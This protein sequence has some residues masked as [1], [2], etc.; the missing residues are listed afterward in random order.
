MKLV[1]VA[2]VAQCYGL[3]ASPFVQGIERGRLRAEVRNGVY[4]TSVAW[5]EDARA[6]HTVTGRG[7]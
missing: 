6:A 4:Y 2:E 1:P 5:V 7:R 3:Q